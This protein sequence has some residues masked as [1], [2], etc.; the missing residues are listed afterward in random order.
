M[1]ETQ[2]LSAPFPLC[3]SKG[4]KVYL[5]SYSPISVCLSVCVGV[6]LMDGSF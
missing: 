5:L 3:G 1:E 2:V 4:V 6:F